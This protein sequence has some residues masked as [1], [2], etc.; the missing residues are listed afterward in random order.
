VTG[1][2]DLD[3]ARHGLVVVAVATA[4]ASVAATTAIAAGATAI[5]LDGPMASIVGFV[6]VAALGGMGWCILAFAA[7]GTATRLARA[8]VVLSTVMV[9]ALA[10][11]ADLDAAR[12]LAAP[13]V[14]LAP[15]V[16]SV[17]S[18]VL[19][20]ARTAW[21]LALVATP[22]LVLAHPRPSPAVRPAAGL[23]AVFVVAVIPVLPFAFQPERLPWFEAAGMCLVAVAVVV[24]AVHQYADRRSSIVCMVAL[25]SVVAAATG[26]AVAIVAVAVGLRT[27]PTA[28]LAAVAASTVAS[29]MWAPT[30]R[31]VAQMTHGRAARPARL[32]SEL[33]E[34]ARTSSSPLD[35]VARIVLERA[36]A[37]QVRLAVTSPQLPVEVA[38][39]GQ[40]NGLP[41]VRRTL[42]A[43][44]EPVGVLE[45]T[46]R[47]AALTDDV[48]RLVD[49][50]ADV[51][52]LL[53]EAVTERRL[54]DQARRSV[55]SAREDERRRLRRDLH[56]GLG[57]SLA[58]IRLGVEA[59][60]SLVETDPDAARRLLDEL[61][62][63]VG[64]STDEV[65][66]IVRNVR[67]PQLDALG[68]VGALDVW[69]SQQPTALEVEVVGPRGAVVP[70]ATETAAY[71][72]AME[73]LTNVVRHSRARRCC[74]RVEVDR[75]LRLDVSDDGIGMS[76][77]T[78][79][80]GIASMRE[81]A[82]E[83]GGSVSFL[84]PLSCD[85]GTCVRVE[86]PLGIPG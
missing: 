74:V 52:A 6:W 5:P 14:T 29:T 54:A 3:R 8:V 28:V 9:A 50:L 30:R 81:R 27:V 85:G 56:D 39:A 37:A 61:A 4:S 72:I 45:V 47:A 20:V 19:A 10:A 40:P 58:G 78:P 55:M 15:D 32:R 73:A 77:I 84:S 69:A 16:V 53:V 7:D 68:L 44:G 36:G 70:P 59:A 42:T 43:M 41:A 65:R 57:P 79:G 82:G 17:L 67:P 31:V 63:N 11:V 83:L 66:R 34:L 25:A 48:A 62:R 21:V 26:V 75:T 35:A 64:E 13:V 24:V 12:R 22:V 49:G 18:A 71:R 76:A 23:G 1:V 86:L 38:E 46:P 51:V 60:R 80:V 2:R 33:G